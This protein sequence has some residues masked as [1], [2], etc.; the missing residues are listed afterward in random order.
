VAEH[1]GFRPT[2]I[3]LSVILGVVAMMAPRAAAADGVGMPVPDV[4][5]KEPAPV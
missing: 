4:L 3:A 1:V 5:S 2:Y